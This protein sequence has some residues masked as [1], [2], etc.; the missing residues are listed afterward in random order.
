MTALNNT[1]IRG[2]A[3]LVGRYFKTRHKQ[4]WTNET[5]TEGD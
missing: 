4:G 2:I 1:Y 3:V 5:P